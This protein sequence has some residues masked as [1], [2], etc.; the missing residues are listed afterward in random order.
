MSIVTELATIIKYRIACRFT[1]KEL[2][3]R[4]EA[5]FELVL[6]D[7]LHSLSDLVHLYFHVKVVSRY[8]LDATV[9]FVTTHQPPT[10]LPE[11]L[12]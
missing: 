10:F 3:Y 6:V 1:P 8:I 9:G 5:S 7:C 2:R 12:A 4:F 11:A